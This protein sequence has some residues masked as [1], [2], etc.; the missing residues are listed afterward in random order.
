MGIDSSQIFR[1]SI[2]ELTSYRGESLIVAL[3]IALDS[4]VG[5]N[6]ILERL[7]PDIIPVFLGM[8]F[9]SADLSPQQ[10][11]CLKRYAPIGCRDE[12]SYLRMQSLGIPCYLNGCV[13]SV[14]Q[15]KARE[16]PKLHNKILM[17]DVPY[18][19]LQHIPQELKEDIVF[20]NQEIYCKNP[21]CHRI[22]CRQTGRK[23]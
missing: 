16:I 18:G 7:S 23:R 21:K 19:V 8:S 4:Y 11:E 9:T 3:N 13:A 5:Y 2:P 20:L 17:I 22:F 10:I 1:T 12:R 6:M 14:L 15:I